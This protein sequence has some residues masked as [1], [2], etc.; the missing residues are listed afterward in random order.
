MAKNDSDNYRKDDPLPQPSPSEM[1]GRQSVR[2]TFKLTERAIEALSVCA[3]HLGIKQ[4]SLFDHLIDDIRSLESIA[5][6]VNSRQFNQL[7]RVQKTYVLSRKTLV[8]LD[9]T[10][11]RSSAPRDALVEYSIQR[12]MPVIEKEAKRHHERKALLGRIAD[13]LAYGEDILESSR[14]VLGEDDPVTVR[15]SGAM[16]A[17]RNAYDT[18]RSFV[19]KGEAIEQFVE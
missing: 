14:E 10:S 9:K 2:A 18:I 1:R 5:E 4:K 17:C 13:H 8:C 19:K 16:A 6:S 15:L 3:V 7:S 11:R 12:L